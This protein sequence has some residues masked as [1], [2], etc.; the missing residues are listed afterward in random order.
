[1]VVHN[2][3]KCLLVTTAIKYKNLTQPWSRLR[4]SVPR[5][6]PSIL[7]WYQNSLYWWKRPYWIK[8]NKK[9]CP[10]WWFNINILYLE[11]Q[12]ERSLEISVFPNSRQLFQIMKLKFYHPFCLF[13]C[14]EFVWILAKALLL[15]CKLLY[16]I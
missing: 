10:H 3:K 1:M 15:I 11:R 5:W 4:F 14:Y 2:W 9:N 13:F 6:P 8:P 12:V 16:V 7:K